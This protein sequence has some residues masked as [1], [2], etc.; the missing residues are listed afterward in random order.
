MTSCMYPSLS[1]VDQYN[2]RGKHIFLGENFSPRGFK[3]FFFLKLTLERNVDLEFYR[4]NQYRWIY[5][6]LLGKL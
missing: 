1:F 3:F 4:S 6:C 5:A 2:V